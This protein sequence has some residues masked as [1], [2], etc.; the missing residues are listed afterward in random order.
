MPIILIVLILFAGGTGVSIVADNSL[1]GDALYGVKVGV[2]ENVRLALAISEESRGTLSGKLADR[3]LAEAEQL[4]A[5]SRLNAELA[6]KIKTN[7]KKHA[8]KIVKISSDLEAKNKLESVGEVNSEFEARLRAHERVLAEFR[9]TDPELQGEVSALLELVRNNISTANSASIGVEAKLV[10]AGGPEIESA[11]K[12]K[13]KATESKI[14]E[15]ESFIA[16]S[17][18]KSKPETT[19]DAEARLQ[20]AKN[21]L[22]AGKVKLNAAQYGEAFQY[23]QKSIRVA[24][25]AQALLSAKIGLE[26]KDRPDN[27][28][29]EPNASGTLRVNSSD[30][31]VDVSGEADIGI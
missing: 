22:E 20:V 9:V 29:K 14:K 31:G 6:L 8:D 11:A 1:P 25:E 12:G 17:K 13:L 21:T 26:D 27:N 28:S 2:N 18:A 10:A 30:K 24:S 16:K 23:F 3:R 19:L 15:V 4:I 7:F 5:E